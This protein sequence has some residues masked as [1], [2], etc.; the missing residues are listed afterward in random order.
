MALDDPEGWETCREMRAAASDD[1]DIRLF[2]NLTGVGNI[3]VNAFQH[4]SNVVVQK[5]IRE[6]FGLVVSES[7]WKGTPVVA[8]RTGGIP[9]QMQGGAGEFLVDSVQGCARRAVWLLRH[10]DEAKELAARG[11][12]L[13]RR[14]F[15]LI[16]LITDELR[17][18][19]E[20]LGERG[21]PAGPVAKMALPGEVRGVVCGMISGTPPRRD[22]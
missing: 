7:L 12:E 14:R 1:P 17:L 8:G 9:L 10:R 19:A 21:Q 20:L 16:R 11:R 4:L 2:T 6:G 18:Y 15:L 22:A 3:Q 5:S 13:V